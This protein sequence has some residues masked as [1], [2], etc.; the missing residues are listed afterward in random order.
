MA[1]GDNLRDLTSNANADVSMAAMFSAANDKALGWI[2]F[3]EILG[4][5][6]SPQTSHFKGLQYRDSWVAKTKGFWGDHPSYRDGYIYV[7]PELNTMW[8]LIKKETN[9][10]IAVEI[11]RKFLSDNV[12]VAQSG[13]KPDITKVVAI[14]TNKLPK[15]MWFETTLKGVSLR[16]GVMAAAEGNGHDREKTEP[17]HLDDMNPHGL[18]AGRTGAGK[19]VALN[20]MIASLL[21]EFA[22]WELMIN[23]ADFKIVEMSRY[24]QTGFEAPHVSKI[25]ATEA[26]EYV[27]SVMYDMYESMSIRQ[28]FFAAVGVQNIKDFRN[29]FGVV[30][31]HVVLLVDEF[32]QMYELAN[33]KQTDIINALIKM[34]TKLGRATG[35]HLLFASQSMSGTLSADVQSNF[36]M[37]ICLPASEDVSTAVL[38]NKA[39]SELRGKGYCYTNCEGGALEANV[40]YRIPFLKSETD[41]PGDLTELQMVLK[42]NRELADVVGYSYPMNFFR[43]TAIR[44]MH[45]DTPEVQSFETDIE[46]FRQSTVRAIEQ[47]KEIE[48]ILLLGDSYVYK[49]PKGRNMNVTLE[50][51]KLKIGDRKNIICIGDTPYDRVYMTELLAM[52][53]A[54]RG[55]KNE[56]VIVN[57]DAVMQEIFDLPRCLTSGGSNRPRE[58]LHKDFISNFI[59]DYDNRRVINEF[60]QYRMAMEKNAAGSD[61]VIDEMDMD[62]KLL[63]LIVQI[64]LPEE[65]LFE[66]D[67][68]DY[69]NTKVKTKDIVER[70]YNEIVTG[71]LPEDYTSLSPREEQRVRDTVGAG[72]SD[73]VYNAEKNEVL[74]LKNTVRNV[75]LRDIIA[76]FNKIKQMYVSG[77]VDG[78][79]NFKN[80][81]TLTYWVIG[82]NGVS[83]I[84]GERSQAG[85]IEPLMKNC[86]NMGIRCIF[87]GGQVRD[88]ADLRRTFGYV[89]IKSSIEDNYSKFDMNM[90]KE[91]KDTVMRFK[92]VGEVINNVKQHLYPVSVDEKMVKTFDTDYAEFGTDDFFSNFN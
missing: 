36:K 33:S 79:F 86:T 73:E 64:K 60:V 67:P 88:I 41:K 18:I 89:F 31:P 55:E 87:V 82:Y 83:S 40:K 74:A 91:F 75:R 58:I 54:M 43:D 6:S 46:L 56:N 26:M 25:A 77:V 11:I 13:M 22:P 20:A 92:S 8:N 66:C 3:E 16:P 19:S 35:Y 70:Y 84:S 85:R 30:L 72:A 34:V 44:P 29:K 68:D 48:D 23:L 37:R 4:G 47:D 15:D 5:E 62:K 76:G 50:Y 53:Y 51:F 1:F 38:G 59:R 49:Q 69:T 57:T 21:M 78:K 7:C 61:V 42:K 12:V 45:G 14:D 71:T 65:G 17:L 90:S 80:M 39:S 27:V 32:Q 10:E 24:G 52:Q 81:N 63:S 28:S 9:Q 2:D